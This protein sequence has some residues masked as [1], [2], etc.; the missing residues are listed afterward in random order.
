MEGDFELNGAIGCEVSVGEGTAKFR[1]EVKESIGVDAVVEFRVDL[2][3]KATVKG[4][5]RPLKRNDLNCVNSEKSSRKTM[6]S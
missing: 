5:I 1:V 2:E 4:G 6:K 3:C